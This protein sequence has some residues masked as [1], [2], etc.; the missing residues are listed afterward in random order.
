MPA[1]AGGRGDPHRLGSH[2]GDAA[3]RAYGSPTAGAPSADLVV[4]ADGV[5]SK[6][7]DGLA[8]LGAA[9]GDAG[10]RHS[11]PAR[12]DGG[13]ACRRRHRYHDRI[14]VGQPPHPLH[15][16]WRRRNLCGAHNGWTRTPP[17]RQR[18]STLRCGARRFRTFRIS[19]AGSVMAATDRFELIKLKRWSSRPWPPSSATRRM[20]CRQNLGQGGAAAM[21]NALALAV[22]LESGTRRA[23]RASPPWPRFGGSACAASP[24]MAAR[25]DDQRF[26]LI[27]SKRS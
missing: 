12:K 24:R 1:R 17:P 21:M 3:R 18:R 16:L 7:R 19:S 11:G 25:P 20:R 9:Q 6:I 8:L 5:N 23:R 22:H 10:W 26:N 14:L 13:R 15:P 4:G 2:R 27:S